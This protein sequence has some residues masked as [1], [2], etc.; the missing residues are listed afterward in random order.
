MACRSCVLV[1]GAL[2]ILI[3]SFSVVPVW[4]TLLYVS[5]D[6]GVV[7]ILMCLIHTRVHVCRAYRLK[8][9]HTL[10]MCVYSH[11]AQSC[12]ILTHILVRMLTTMLIREECGVLY[13]LR[14]P[15]LLFRMYVM[16]L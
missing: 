15:L 9:S 10:A 7:C 5:F 6:L 2:F 12:H 4:G 13:T 16:V 8:Q 3:I 1:R 14:I 11:H